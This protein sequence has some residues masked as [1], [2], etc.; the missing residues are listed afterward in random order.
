MT[1]MAAGNVPNEYDKADIVVENV[2]KSATVA[3]Y[4]IIGAD[5]DNGLVGYKW[6]VGDNVNQKLH[7]TMRVM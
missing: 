6:L 2:E 1:T 4:K 5:Y 7:L 3:A